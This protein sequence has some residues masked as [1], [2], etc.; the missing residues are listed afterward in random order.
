MRLALGRIIELAKFGFVGVVHNLAG[1]LVYLL[2]TNY[3]L[4]PKLAVTILYPISAL[5][6]FYAHSKFSFSYQGEH[7]AAFSRYIVANL[8]CFSCNLSMLYVFVDLMHF[9]HELIQ[10]TAIFSIAL[11]FFLLSKF[12]IFKNSQSD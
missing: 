2:V 10:V 1:Y 9:S 4:E 5:I 6:A 8:I 12:Y 3:W 11:L 7:S